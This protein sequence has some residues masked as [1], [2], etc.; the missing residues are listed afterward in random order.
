VGGAKSHGSR[1][2]VH[3]HLDVEWHPRHCV[4]GMPQWEAL[5]Y[6]TPYIPNPGSGTTSRAQEVATIPNIPHPQTQ[7][8]LGLGV[9]I[10]DAWNAGS[11]T[12]WSYQS[13][14]QTMTVDWTNGTWTTTWNGIPATQTVTLAPNQW[15]YGLWTWAPWGWSVSWDGQS[16][17][18]TQAIVWQSGTYTATFGANAYYTNVLVNDAVL[19]ASQSAGWSATILSPLYCSTAYQGLYRNSN[20][21]GTT[22]QMADGWAYTVGITLPPN[23]PSTA[24]TFILDQSALNQNAL[25]TTSSPVTSQVTLEATT[26]QLI[27]AGAWIFPWA[28][29]Y[30]T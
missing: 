23:T 22:G 3:P 7:G 13:G 20:F 18:G 8:M 14:T 4:V 30:R 28:P 11:G 29:G 10:T 12:L 16:Q 1:R 6:S 19:P 9:Y 5:G 21:S 25:G 2:I 26:Q 27:E 17:S 15:H 24:G